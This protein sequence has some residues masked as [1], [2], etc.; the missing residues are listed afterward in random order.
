MDYLTYA[1]LQRGRDGDAERVV[2]ELRAMGP[3]VAK[4]FKVGYAATAMPVR[5]AVERE[6]WN[7]A[8]AFEPLPGAPPHVAAISHWGRA[9][10]NARLGHADIAAAD[11]A[12]IDECEAQ[13]RSLGDTYWAT[14]IG[15]LSRE[16]QAWIAN[17]QRRQDEAVSLMRAAA[18]AEDSL[19]K[20]P[21]TPGPIV[22]AR[23]QLGRLLLE[24]H[25]ATDALGE[26]KQALKD[27]P[28]RR[29]AL[30]AAAQ[31]AD[32][33]GDKASAAAF[34]QLLTGD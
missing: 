6:R 16:A 32:A 31:A 3:L 2:G 23:E 13:A 30:E 28:G 1:Y 34:R 22:P 27:S 25:R 20:L 15:V 5:L 19:E 11:V 10:A 26:L 9:L 21:V 14:Q 33:T 24:Q 4:D 18:D 8:V 29:A 17:A 12:R 7:E